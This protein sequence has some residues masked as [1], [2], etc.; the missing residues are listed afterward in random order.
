VH[1]GEGL[2][3]SGHLERARATG[4]RALDLA[5]THKERGHEAWALHL[6]GDIT[7][8]SDRPQ[9]DRALDYYARSLALAEEL[10]MRPLVARLH[11]GLGQLYRQAGMLDKA[12]EHLA[13]ALT[14]LCEMDM[15]FWSARAARDLMGL[16]AIF[17]VARERAGVYNYLVREFAGQPV[18]VILDRRRGARR[19]DDGGQRGSERRVA[20]RR[21]HPEIDEAVRD[22]GLAVL[23]RSPD[24]P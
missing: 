15:R 10:K 17:V 11:L 6:L 3:A 5:R 7:A 8:A 19:Q 24:T 13:L 21:R 22:R 23:A 9:T 2:L 20:E 4:Q 16:G 1:L 14:R 18:E 12:E